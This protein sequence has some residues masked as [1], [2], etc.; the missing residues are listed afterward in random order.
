MYNRT[1]LDYTF[2]PFSII[3]TILIVL[4]GPKV[5]A[6][7]FIDSPSG[8]PVV[9]LEGYTAFAPYPLPP[10][11][12]YNSLVIPLAQAQQSI[13]ELAGV[14]RRLPNP[15]LLQ[16]PFMRR[17]AVS[18]SAIEGTI[19]TLTDL[20]VYEAAEEKGRAADDTHEVF[21]YVLALETAFNALKKLPISGRLLKQ[22]H[23][24]L[25]RGVPQDRGSKKHPGIY[26]STDPAWT[27]ARFVEE[28]RF[29]FAPP[30]T[31]E[32]CM[33]ALETFINEDTG[34]TI[35]EIIKAA[36]IHY[37]FETIHPFHDGNGRVGRL[38]VPLYLCATGVLPQ[39]LLFLSP[40]LERNR[41]E[42][43]QRLYEVSRLGAWEEWIAFF[44]NGV[45]EQSKDFIFRS[46][47]LLDLQTEYKE[48]LTQA[49]ASARLLQLVDMALE[50]PIFSIP[51]AAEYLGVTYPSA[52]KNIDRLLKAGILKPT[53][54][55][56][57]SGAKLFMA[58]E[59]FSLI[60]DPL[61]TLDQSAA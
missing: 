56:T 53:M 27:G 57:A 33:A 42:Y 16:R 55:T 38:M 40:Y 2:S 8:K 48:R 10:K 18:S 12:N 28:A 25:L 46:Q 37:Q 11:I 59:I 50:R 45:T 51:N 58:E 23:I 52:K 34:A 15:H 41:E 6:E 21:N 1:A 24:T 49:R 30:G 20:L 7:D 54:L 22:T 31:V 26:R 9:S 5:K 47:R 60:Y 19:T 13:G 44:L 29:V 32:D 39:P 35:P 43:I 14:G 17:E 36:L 3:C 4:L 61:E